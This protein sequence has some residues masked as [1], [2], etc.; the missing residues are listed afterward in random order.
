MASL[1][2]WCIRKLYGRAFGAAAAAAAGPIVATVDIYPIVLFFCVC[3]Y[4]WD[5]VEVREKELEDRTVS[6][7]Y[8]DA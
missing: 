6:E 1:V 7:F 5:K 2:V 3:I 8:A 4:V